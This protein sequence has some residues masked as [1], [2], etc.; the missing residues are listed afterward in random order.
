M[1]YYKCGIQGWGRN[2]GPFQKSENC[3]TEMARHFPERD[4]KM[5]IIGRIQARTEN[6]RDNIKCSHCK[7]MSY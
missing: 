4:N 3:L 5:F 1:K 2:N 6:M 7:G